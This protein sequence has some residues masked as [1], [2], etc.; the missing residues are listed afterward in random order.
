MNKLN[1]FFTIAF[2]WGGIT[3]NAQE[4]PPLQNFLPQEYG[5]EN[6]NWAI[7]QGD[8]KTVYI[9]NS[10][11]LLTFNGAQWQLY[12]SPNKTILRSVG[13]LQ[14]KIYTGCYMEF[15][16]WEY[17]NQKQLV[18]SSLSDQLKIPLIEDEQFWDIHFL[19]QYVLFQSLDRIYIY[20]TTSQVF[21][22][23]DL[24][25]EITK[26]Y[27][28][29]NTVYF[30]IPGEGL[31]RIINGSPQLFIDHPVIQKDVLINVIQQ[32]DDLI[33][34]TQNNGFYKYDGDEVKIW[35]V[36]ANEELSQNTIYSAKVTS[37]NQL[38]IGS[39]SNGLY[40]LNQS[41]DLI[42]H[43]NQEQGL[44]NNTVLSLFEDLDDN[45]WLGLDNG[46]S[47]MNLNS[48]FRVYQDKGGKIGTVYTTYLDD[49]MLYLGT[50][51]GLFYKEKKSKEKFKLIPGTGGQVW[52]LR[53]ING[54]LFCGHNL[55]TF[56]VN[57]GEAKLISS[58][59]GAW[60][61]K[62]ISDKS[63][64][65]LQGNYDGLHVLDK[66]KGSWK[67]INKVEGFDISSRFFE[68]AD[69]TTIL[70]SHEYKGV[71]KLQV[72]KAFKNVLNYKKVSSAPAGLT[73]GLTMF[74]KQILYGYSNG[75]LSYHT[76]KE[77]FIRDTVL[78]NGFNNQDLYVSGK[79]TNDEINNRLWG[80][81]QKGLIYFTPGN[82]DDKLKLNKIGFPAQLRRDIPG[83]E[84]I[85]ALQEDTYLIGFSGGYTLLHVDEIQDKSYFIKINSVTN[86]KRNT[87]GSFV[88]LN[89][90]SQF[91]ASENNF[92]ITY[93]VPEYD[94]FKAV[95]YQYNLEGL[96]DEWSTWSASAEAYF[97]N[98][99]FGDYTFKVRARVGETITK[100][101]ATYTF[102]I[103][104]PWY[105]SIPAIL[106]YFL[107][108][109]GILFLVQYYNRKYYKQQKL[110]LIAKN[111]RELKMTQYQSERELMKLRNEKLQNDIDSK[112]RELAASTMSIVKKN[113]LLGTIKKELLPVKDDKQVKSVIRTIDKN[114]SNTKDWEFFEEAFNNAD[115]DFLQKLKH[116]HPK[117][118]PNDLKLCAYLRLNLS[119]KEIAP[120]LNISVRS[121]EIK[122]YRL[123]KKM[124]LE[125]QTSLVE[126]ILSI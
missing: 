25:K 67:V 111:E 36:P 59:P 43:L 11:G 106:I 81:T 16:Y 8:D 29:D 38:I 61:F 52:K 92:K 99:P 20:D 96:Y 100:N 48:P 17:N 104:R 50:N 122:R 63:N 4:L 66:I 119:S 70:V 26:S 126:Y 114:L 1:L 75:V 83:F 69:P 7:S 105:I 72:D 46:I 56:I 68:I 24:E 3:F 95:E 112:S 118:T 49:N 5:A 41:G 125:H 62:Q 34:I 107:I 21:E 51:Q 78:S 60:D 18:Y 64:L 55:G 13:A 27:K 33:L 88:N 47:V 37:D 71:F 93:N 9:A 31:Y 14:D 23:V 90:D 101:T 77:E 28:V 35:Q 80:V 32:E 42:Y 74:N 76:D 84:N 79:L 98:L 12:E 39:I 113:E 103:A 19:D 117:L 54:T 85:T 22:I 97:E 86:S 30:Q 15:G 82:L 2:F 57:K 44:V 123:R 45:I 108:L 115:K 91:N 89:Q 110:K 65:I 73:S 109:C 53:A 10:K 94:K 87:L 40:L 102:S 124:N 6:Q 120:L 116:E 121:V 58:I